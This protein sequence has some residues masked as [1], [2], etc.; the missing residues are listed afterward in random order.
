M[1]ADSRDRERCSESIG[2]LVL[3]SQTTNAQ[4]RNLDFP[5]KKQILSQAAGLATIKR[6]ALMTETWDAETIMSRE[7]R[8]M[9]IVRGVL[10]LDPSGRQGQSCARRGHAFP[11]PG[12]TPGFTSGQPF[13]KQVQDPT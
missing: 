13:P 1:F 7:Q 6:E 2:N 5:D 12:P 4:V 10:C 3:L 9:G 11:T 8:L